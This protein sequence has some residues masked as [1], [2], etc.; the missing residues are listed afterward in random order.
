MTFLRRVLK[1][2]AALWALHGVALA[3]APAQLLRLFDQPIPQ[4]GA[5][6]RIAGVMALV[7]AMLMVL[8]SQNLTQTWWWAWAFAVLEAGVATV[9]ILNAVFGVPADAAAW[10]WWFSGI[11]S[12]VFGTLDL[13]GIARAGQEKPIV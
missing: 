5:W 3:L 10:P 13:I 2:Q 9:S 8:V 1:V 11:A 7:L 4:E 6:L 12:M